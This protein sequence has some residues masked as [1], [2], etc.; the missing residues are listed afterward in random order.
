MTSHCSAL[1][2]VTSPER[3]ILPRN[4]LAMEYPIRFRESLFRITAQ[5]WL[6]LGRIAR[7][8]F[9]AIMG[10]SSVSC[11][12]EKEAIEQRLIIS[13]SRRCPPEAQ[14]SKIIPGTSSLTCLTKFT[15]S[16]WFLRSPSPRDSA[17]S[18]PSPIVSL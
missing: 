17:P 18:Q 10:I 15:D 7:C 6:C 16:S 1:R 2:S 13:G 5:I 3:H 8:R 11:A 9:A 12:S 14:F 4:V